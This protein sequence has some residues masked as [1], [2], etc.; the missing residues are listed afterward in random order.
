MSPKVPPELPCSIAV[1]VLAL[2][3]PAL[4]LLSQALAGDLSCILPFGENPHL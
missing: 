2:P 1:D 4:L 3:G